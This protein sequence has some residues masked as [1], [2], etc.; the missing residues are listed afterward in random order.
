MKKTIALTIGI[1]L[2]CG[3]LLLGGTWV[4]ARDR[5]SVV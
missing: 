5:K 1:A 4:Y 2:L 3:L